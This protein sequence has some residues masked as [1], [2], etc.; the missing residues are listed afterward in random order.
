MQVIKRDGSS[1]PLEIEKI[2]LATK[3]AT[4]GLNAS[5]SELEVASKLMLFDGIKTSDI[6]KSLIIS[7]AGLIS[8]EQPDYTYVAARLLLQVIYKDVTGGSVEYPSLRRYIVNGVNINRLDKRLLDF[9]LDYLQEVIDPSRD[10]QFDYVGL[11]TIADRYLITTQP[12]AKKAGRIIEL[13]QHMWMRVAMGLSINEDPLIKSDVAKQFYELLSKFEYVS[14]TPTLFNSGT[15]KPQLSSCYGNTVEDSISGIFDNIAE[16]AQLSK[17]AGGIGTDWTRVRSAGS[18]VYGTNGKSSGIIPYLKVYN[19]TAVAVNQGGKRNGA[20]AP[21]LEPWHPDFLD[22]IDLKKNSGDER[23]RAHDIFPA[24]WIPDLFMQR[25]KEDGIWS[26]FSPQDAP[27]LHE[28]YS[29]DFE[30][31]YVD[32]E[33]NSPHLIRSQI[34]AKDL[35]RKIITS[36]FETGHPWITFKDTHNKRNPQDHIGVIHNS[37]LC[38]EV[39]LNNSDSET[40]VCNLGSINLSKIG[41]EGYDAFFKRVSPIVI[42]MLDNVVDI[43]FYP[44]EKARYSNLKS[45]PIGLGM[46]GYTEHLVKKGIDWESNRHLVEANYLTEAFSYYAISASCELAQERGAYETFEGSKWDRGI[47]PID[48]A[49]DYC[50]VFENPDFTKAEYNGVSKD[51]NEL[52]RRIQLHGMRNSNVMAI[53]PTATIATIVGTTQCIEPIYRRTTEK[54]N[55]SGVFTFIDPCLRHGKKLELCKESFEI[56][57]K[58]VI[59][60]AAARQRWIDQSQSINLFVDSDRITGSELSNFYM[61]SWELGLKSTYYL[62]TKSAKAKDDFAPAKPVDEFVSVPGVVCSISAGPNCESCQ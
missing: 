35:W 52:R 50:D 46:M 28:K 33:T 40:F 12:E 4:D 62:K 42:R 37:N 53:A 60:A 18:P 5:Q 32:L 14:S 1:E 9:D 48:T 29:R 59:R 45:R 19:D 20:F 8:V 58:W 38:T 43:N 7:A 16:C 23:R 26:F 61:M 39:S 15:T 55:L 36:L 25:V 44:S 49:I 2:H 57:Q 27:Q 24:A 22:F 6:Q 51:W 3:Y 11:Q 30:A 21:Y 17:Y 47:L 13:P 10:F 34:Q 31:A 41:L 54:E 56:D